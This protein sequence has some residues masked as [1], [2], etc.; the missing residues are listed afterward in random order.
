M[1]NHFLAA[2]VYGCVYYPGYT[3]KGTATKNKKWVSK[4]TDRSDKTDMEID[5]GKRL[6]KIPHYEDH[7]VLVERDCTIPYK[8]LTAMK[9]GC[10]LVK[11][12]KPYILLYSKYIPSVELYKYFQENTLFI[13]IFRCYY[14]LCEKVALLIEN[15][16][17]HHDLHFANVLYSTETAKL[18]IIDFGL[19][20]MADHFQK[21]SYLNKIFSR[22][23]PDW[24]WYSLE[25]HFI[26]YLVQHGELTDKTVY[27][28]IETY[29][30]KH[31]VFTLIPVIRTQFM[32]TALD[33]FLPLTELD[34][35]EGIRHLLSFWNTWDY[36][37]LALRFLYIYVENKIYYPAFFENLLTMIDAN[38]E[39]RPNVLP[40]RNANKKTIQSFDLSSSKSTYFS[41]NSDISTES[42]KNL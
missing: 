20:I 27:H 24:N 38:P 33:Y 6:K 19:A 10:D 9:V 15:N 31:A 32:K 34:P 35:K 12:E 26:S 25:I 14:Q 39:K 22:Y 21:D 5:V 29:L 16:I 23:I 1:P 4:L 37:E 8:S 28:T 11:K 40:I 7:F 30:A 17:V 18:Y 3:C 13:R 36:Y 41:I 42:V 2:G